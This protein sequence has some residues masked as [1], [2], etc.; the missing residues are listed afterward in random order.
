M[1]FSKALHSATHHGTDKMIKIMKKY[2]WGDYSKLK[3]LVYNQHLICQT[4][5]P[6]KTIKVLDR[7][8]PPPTRPFE[9]LQKDFIQLPL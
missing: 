9:H 4:Y 2:W 6:G 1:P 8:F 5:N 7:A 3:K